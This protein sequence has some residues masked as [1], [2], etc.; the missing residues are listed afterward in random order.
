MFLHVVDAIHVGE[1]RIEITFNNGR[2]GIADLKDSLRGKVFE[3]LKDV[4]L[5]SQLIVDKELETVTWPNG[6]D[7]APEFLYFK[8]FSDLPELQAQ[9][10]EWGYKA[11]EGAR[12]GRSL[13]TRAG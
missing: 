9:F 2:R 1:Y 4:R 6:A 13:N 7:F 5:F 3:P 12:G 11:E 8:A 10:V